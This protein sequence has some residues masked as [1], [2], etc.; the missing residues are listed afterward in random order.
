MTV[1][2]NNA[3]EHKRLDCAF[4]GAAGINFDLGNL[5]FRTGAQPAN[6]DAAKT[7][8]V[9]A[10]VDLPAD[11]FQAAGAVSPRRVDK[12]GTWDD[13][14]ADAPGT[15][16]W[17]CLE[18]ATGTYRIDFSVTA[19]GGGGD[20]TVNN[21]VLALGQPFTITAFDLTALNL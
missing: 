20:I 10:T 15:V 16:G 13:N 21:T 19:T 1:R 14:A 2:T 18:D 8:T 12:S 17:A 4:N 9:V 5:T 3:F 7:G 11:A 6:A